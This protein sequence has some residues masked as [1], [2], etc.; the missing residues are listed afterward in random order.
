MRDIQFNYGIKHETLIVKGV[1]GEFKRG[2]DWRKF[3][4][5]KKRKNELITIVTLK[6]ILQKNITRINKIRRT[7]SKVFHK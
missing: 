1:F 6:V 5:E 7:N 4:N 3:K 2:V